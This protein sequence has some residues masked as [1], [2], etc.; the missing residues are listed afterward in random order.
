MNNTKNLLNAIESDWGIRFTKVIISYR[1]GGHTESQK[2]EI[3][4]YI[5]LDEEDIEDIKNLLYKKY[6][7]IRVEEL[8]DEKKAL[9]DQ[10]IK[11]ESGELNE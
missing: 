8:K 5:D 3:V 9:M 11:L 7:K 10:I 2:E 4:G 1:D 6:S